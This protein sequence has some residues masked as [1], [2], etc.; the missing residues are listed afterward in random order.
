MP[1]NENKDV[2]GTQMLS[3][4]IGQTFTVTSKN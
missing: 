2:S 4:A 3:T 1:W